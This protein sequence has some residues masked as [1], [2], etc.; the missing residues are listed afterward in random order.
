M[1]TRFF[2]RQPGESTEQLCVRLEERINAAYIAS[3][4]A[5]IGLMEIDKSSGSPIKTT[6]RAAFLR[7]EDAKEV[8]VHSRYEK[9]VRDL[10][11]KGI[12]VSPLR[13]LDASGK[14]FC[15]EINILL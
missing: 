8:L 6:V 11:A 5:Q 4:A 13:T 15:Y 7:P 14:P 9:A 2:E 3:A 10:S 12:R 1:S